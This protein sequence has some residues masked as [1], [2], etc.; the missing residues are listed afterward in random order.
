MS[1]IPALVALACVCPL[2]V[3]AQPATTVPNKSTRTTAVPS[4]V[5]KMAELDDFSL[6]VGSITFN[7][8]S[9][10]EVKEGPPLRGLSVLRLT[11]SYR[12]RSGKAACFVFVAVGLDSEGEV[13]WACSDMGQAGAGAVGVLPDKLVIGVPSRLRKQTASIRFRVHLTPT[14]AAAAVLAPPVVAA[15]PL[16]VPPSA[17]V[18]NA[19]R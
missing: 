3:G 9:L 11:G 18:A 19:L 8:F 13:L 4:T 15:S 12:N 10:A 1:R 7:N 6:K 16:V 5:V 17:P 14:P 2:L